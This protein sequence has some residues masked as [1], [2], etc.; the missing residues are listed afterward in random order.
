[1]S[2]LRPYHREQ[3]IPLTAGARFIRGFKRI[4]LVLGV[5]IFLADWVS[6]FS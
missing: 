1:M 4:G 2:E 6:P 5:L 3:P